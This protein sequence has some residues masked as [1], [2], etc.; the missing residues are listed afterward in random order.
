MNVPNLLSLIR[1]MLV[2]VF[3]VAFFASG[4]NPW[5]PVLI[6]AAASLTDVL[7]GYI[8]RKFNQTTSLG[9]VLDPLADKLM[10]GTVL[11]CIAAA[12]LVPLWAAAF[13]VFTEGVLGLGAMFLLRKTSDVMPANILGKIATVVFFSVCVILMIF[14]RL[15]ETAAMF[16]ITLAL[17]LAA[18]AFVRYLWEF[19]RILRKNEIAQ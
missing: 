16:L 17:G 13:F 12:G 2:P 1:V 8:A 6:Y 14:T 19:I 9:R 4:G 3:A 7:D 18:A 10:N 15:S 5:P 11:V